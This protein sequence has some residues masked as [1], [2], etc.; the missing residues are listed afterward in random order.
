METDRSLLANIGEDISRIANHFDPPS[1]SPPR[2]AQQA[3]DRA[4]QRGI[5]VFSDALDLDGQ[6]LALAR[7]MVARKKDSGRIAALAREQWRLKAGLDAVEQ[8]RTVLR[9]AVRA[10]ADNPKLGLPAPF[11]DFME[12]LFDVVDG[13]VAQARMRLV[14]ASTVTDPHILSALGIIVAT[15]G[16][17]DAATMPS[18]EPADHE[19]ETPAER[20]ECDK[21][22][23][24][25]MLS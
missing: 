20:A 4:L 21:R 23:L 6:A 22:E 17:G 1:A 5:A 7:G 3:F 9:R 18:T 8:E 15:D 13:A 25:E 2:T 16:N 10:W 14:A 12:M 11:L 24:A 19:P